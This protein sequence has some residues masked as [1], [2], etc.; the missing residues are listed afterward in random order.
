MYGNATSCKLVIVLFDRKLQRR[1]TVS[2][3]VLL[4]Y[5]SNHKR[6]KMNKNDKQMRIQNWWG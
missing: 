4:A 6:C 1:G 5:R 2:T 3:C